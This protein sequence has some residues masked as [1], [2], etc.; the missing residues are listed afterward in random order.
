[1]ML[2]HSNRTVT[3][4]MTYKKYKNVLENQRNENWNHRLKWSLKGLAWLYVDLGLHKLRN[5]FSETKEGIWLPRYWFLLRRPSFVRYDCNAVGVSYREGLGPL[6]DRKQITAEGVM[7][8]LEILTV[9]PKVDEA[10]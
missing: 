10:P 8:H 5:Y 1:M 4:I 3:R 6:R 7:W 2:L 9:L